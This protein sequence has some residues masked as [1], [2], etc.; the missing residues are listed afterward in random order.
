[1]Q[2]LNLISLYFKLTK[3]DLEY[4]QFWQPSAYNLK[5]WLSICKDTETQSVFPSL[6]LLD[7]NINV[8]TVSNIFYFLLAL[9]LTFII[10]TELQCVALMDLEC[11]NVTHFNFSW[12]SSDLYKELLYLTILYEN[13]KV[14]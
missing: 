10:N 6:L 5:K 2:G 11:I 14:T 1:M 3:S 12:K 4:F 13:M 7:D 9:G 8:E